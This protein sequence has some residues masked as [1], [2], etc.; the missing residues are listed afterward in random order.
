MSILSMYN[1]VLKTRLNTNDGLGEEKI[2]KVLNDYGI[3]TKA[4]YIT[5]EKLKKRSIA[6]YH[7]LD[8]WVTVEKI[9]RKNNKVFVNDS[10]KQ[11]AEWLS[12][13]DFC[14]SW[15]TTDTTGYVIECRLKRSK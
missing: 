15:L 13:D 11:K 3:Q 6:Y 4:K 2:K 10:D 9:D 14:N 12:K 1:K 7:R 5:W 8:H